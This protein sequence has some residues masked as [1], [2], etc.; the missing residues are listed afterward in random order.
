MNDYDKN[1]YE[2]EYENDEENE[3]ESQEYHARKVSTRLLMIIQITVCCII[4][5]TM[6]FLR[7]WGGNAYTVIRSWYIQNINQTIIPDEQIENIKHNVIQLF[8]VA[9]NVPAAASSQAGAAASQQAAN[10]QANSAS[11]QGSSQPASAASQQS[12]AQSGV[13]S[14]P[15][16]SSQAAVSS[17]PPVESQKLIG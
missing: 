14:K 9:S 3:Y 16:G 5:F 8:P 7:I 17:L 13:S 12:A 15:T 10:S 6:I 11:A 2:N 1:E 4:L